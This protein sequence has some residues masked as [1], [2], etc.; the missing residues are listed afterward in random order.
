MNNNYLYQLTLRHTK[1]GN[2]TMNNNNNNNESFRGVMD[3]A[4]E[5]QMSEIGNFV[6]QV[7]YTSECNDCAFGMSFVEEII[8][9]CMNECPAGRRNMEVLDHE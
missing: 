1:K 8:D 3:K 5:Y 9:Y 6:N 2:N 4:R 7:K